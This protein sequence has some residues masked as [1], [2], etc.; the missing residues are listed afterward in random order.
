MDSQPELAALLRVADER[1]RLEGL[2]AYAARMPGG[3]HGLAAAE[4]AI[5]LASAAG[6]SESHLC[7]L[8]A[9][10]KSALSCMELESSV[11]HGKRM[12]E[13]AN[14]S[15]AADPSAWDRA[16]DRHS[17]QTV[18]ML[19][20]G[21]TAMAVSAFRLSDYVESLR[22]AQV[23]LHVKRFLRDE[24]GE[25]QALNGI[26]WGYDKMGLY[27]QAL[28]H[29]FRSL[30]TLE[31]VA[32]ELTADPLNGIAA[33]YLDVGRP[34]R[35][36]EYGQLAFKA[37]GPG[38][39]RKRERSTAL[40]LIGLGH[41]AAG[42]PGQADAFFR[43]AIESADPYGKSLTLLSLG[44]LQLARGENE[45]ALR[46]YGEA[47]TIQRSSNSRRATSAALVGVGNAHLQMGAPEA[48]LEPL[49]E[50][51]AK[52]EAS[53]AP[54]EM[55][56]AHLGL[57]HALKA[58]GR[59]DEALVHFEAFHAQN[60]KV[61]RQTAD[62]RTQLLTIQFDV[63]RIQKDREIDRLRNVELARA[64]TDLRE[65]HERLERQAAKLERLSL[66]DDLTS[67]HNRRAFEERLAD[68]VAR[69]RRT[70]RPLSVLMVDLDDFKLVNDVHSHAA[71]DAVLKATAQALLACVR[72]VDTCARIGGEEF[73]I[74]LPETDLAGATTVAEK[75]VLLV[76][77]RNLYDSGVNVTA[78]AGVATLTA[79]ETPGELV[80]RAD[81]ALYRAKRE[82]KNR[83]M[84]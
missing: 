43:R 76:H 62:L 9:A 4:H 51:L 55:A 80:S 48:A 41:S 16:L 75:V 34:E 47:L 39:S 49:S 54:V 74:L 27:Q 67:L 64:F 7:A 58:L 25:A 22:F 28:T 53:R 71:G 60:E 69:A 81:A 33:A 13:L 29:H 17:F 6:N 77:E 59:F 24:I 73:I 35:A 57:S 14:L 79:S 8:A 21:A 72:D 56:A 5:D 46:S 40:R 19:G 23:E 2:L 83:V 10:T 12:L 65:M 45:A 15:P 30:R 36:V 3:S 38:E 70:N 44:D 68:E 11:R 63:E 66:T 78:S 82:G 84:V 61:L 1:E 26:G 20:A 42:D 52:G 32:P 37:A 18:T 31:R 50:A